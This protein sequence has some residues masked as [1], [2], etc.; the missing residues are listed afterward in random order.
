MLFSKRKPGGVKLVLWA[1]TSPL[2]EMRLSDKSFPHESKMTIL[3]DNRAT[4]I[5]IYQYIFDVHNNMSV[6]FLYYLAILDLY[7]TV[8]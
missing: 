6:S 4:S 2:N 3:T 8:D 7:L 5:I 1:Q